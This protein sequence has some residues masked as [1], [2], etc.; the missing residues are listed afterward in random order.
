MDLKIGYKVQIKKYIIG[1]NLPSH[2][3]PEMEKYMGQ[4]LTIKHIIEPLN[5]I[6]FEQCPQWYWKFSD[7]KQIRIFEPLNNEFFKI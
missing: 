5:E 4:T 6:Y 2:V 7:V 3:I 1:V